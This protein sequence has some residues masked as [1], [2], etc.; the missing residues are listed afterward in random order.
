MYVHLLV[1]TVPYAQ[2]GRSFAHIVLVNRKW[3]G[4]FI[5]IRRG[6]GGSR[7]VRGASEPGTWRVGVSAA[8]LTPVFRKIERRLELYL[9]LMYNV[10]GRVCAQFFIKAEPK[11][12]VL[13]LSSERW[14]MAMMKRSRH[15]S[16]SD[17][18][19]NGSKRRK[20]IYANHENATLALQLSCFFIDTF[21]V[22]GDEKFDVMSSLFFR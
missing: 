8:P 17:E 16:S 19:D 21:K 18:S 13:F 4:W 1:F 12:F 3:V 20:Q 5:L 6:E 7:R 22:W 14:Q 9:R 15:Q 11:H 2:W 10:K